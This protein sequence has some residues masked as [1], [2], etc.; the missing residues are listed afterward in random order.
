MIQHF[1]VLSQILEDHYMRSSKSSIKAL[2]II[3]TLLIVVDSWEESKS[4]TLDD[5]EQWLKESQEKEDNTNLEALK[6]KRVN[7]L[8]EAI[9]LSSKSAYNEIIANARK[10]T[11]N[12]NSIIYSAPPLN[13]NTE[14]IDASLIQ[15]L[16]EVG[17]TKEQVIKAYQIQQRIP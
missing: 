7:T 10:S 1:I 3:I 17:L 6:S 5:A 12:H 4:Y 15:D 11:Y 2:L 8:G 13:Q 14:I 16:M 9:N